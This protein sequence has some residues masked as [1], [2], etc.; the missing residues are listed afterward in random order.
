MKLFSLIPTQKKYTLVISWWGT[1]WFYALGILKW[2][3]ELWYKEKIEAIYGVSAWA[4]VGAYRGAGFSAQ[5]IY[6]IFFHA[7]PF[8]IFSINIFSKQSLLKENFF[9]KQFTKDLPKDISDLKIKTYIW[10]T[11]V[12]TG[13]FHLFEY[14]DLTPILL[15]SISIPGIF[16]VVPH[17][18][19]LLMDGGVTNN[20]PVDLAKKQYPKNEIIGIAL[21]KFQENQTIKTIFDNLSVSFEILL[22][23]HTVENM[24][25]V[26]HLFYKDLKLK[27]LDIS[28]KNMH[29]AYLDGYK[30]CIEHFKK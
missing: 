5:E 13:L 19:H 26:K 8:N 16:P 20:F 11:D 3:E 18:K 21:N 6:D 17:K 4:L 22:R 15:G 24:S 7:R 29:K 1:R 27:V 30:D 9:E 23:H 25:V 14:G 12:K 28:K 10:T 2:L